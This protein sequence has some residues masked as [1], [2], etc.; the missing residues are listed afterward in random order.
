MAASSER[1][2]ETPVVRTCNKP[3]V[4]V[5]L[6]CMTC[7][8][9]FLLQPMLT[10]QQV[11]VAN[12]T[13]QRRLHRLA[14]AVAA[15]DVTT[16]AAARQT[17]NASHTHQLT[18]M[19]SQ[20]SQDNFSATPAM[21]T[22]HKLFNTDDST[23]FNFSDSLIKLVSQPRASVISE[24]IYRETPMKNRIFRVIIWRPEKPSPRDQSLRS[25][26]KR[27]PYHNCR[28]LRTGDAAE[29]PRADAVVIHMSKARKDMFPA[30]RKRRQIWIAYQ[31][32][33][34]GRGI[35]RRRFN[36]YNGLFNATALYERTADIYSGYGFIDTATNR[37]F[38]SSRRVKVT[39]PRLVVWLASHCQTQ[40]RR[41][42]Y[43]KELQKHIPVD[44]YGACGNL[45]CAKSTKRACYRMIQETY[46]FHLSFENSLCVDYITEKAW[47]IL[48][49]NVVPIVL[50][51]ADYAAF[52]PPKSYIDI[53]D[54][55]SPKQ[56]A[57]YLYMLDRN[58]TLYREYFDWKRRYRS[59][60]RVFNSCQW[61]AYLNRVDFNSTHIVER[62]DRFYDPEH[63]C[64]DP[65]T[66]YSGHAS[67]G[68]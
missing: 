1:S 6:A 39:R 49:F 34:P 16:P 22:R 61:C 36:D 31:R 12:M 15:P 67:L 20:S 17:S 44:I 24:N 60:A 53:R 45:T 65:K 26:F 30:D 3:L 47:N 46:K 10:N 58:D 18:A 40:R 48:Q 2:T 55:S 35:I 43:V 21:Y 54:F 37:S 64:V 28:Y 41:E 11:F 51:A 50:G 14:P 38:N 29:L 33:S 52:L 56:L 4:F 27:C 8:A 13:V 68:L 59:V 19:N 57:D 66:Y 25:S 63:N 32:E 5:G 62:L 9:A 42:D 7:A 23:S